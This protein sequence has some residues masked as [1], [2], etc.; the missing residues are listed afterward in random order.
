VEVIKSGTIP[1]VQKVM[2]K[3][4]PYIN[5]RYPIWL[6][7]KIIGAVSA[8]QDVEALSSFLMSLEQ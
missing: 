6:E 7:G 5:S 1:P 3:E 4:R 2:I 8:F